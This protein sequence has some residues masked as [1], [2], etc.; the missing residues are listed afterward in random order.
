MRK[1]MLVAVGMLSAAVVMP[2]RAQGSLAGTWNTS[3][4]VG[5]RIE[6]GVETSMGKRPAVMTLTVKGDSVLGTW[7]LPADGSS[8]AVP[9]NPLRGTRVGNKVTLKADPIER[10]RNI[11]GET[12]LVKLVNSFAFELKGD[13]LVGTSKVSALDGSFESSDREFLAKRKM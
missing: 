10:S 4:D 13:S 11:N 2:A 6:N 8:P 3:V 12:Q 9:P 5:M 1:F 7:T